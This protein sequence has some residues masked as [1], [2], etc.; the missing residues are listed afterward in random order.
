[1]KLAR[2]RLLRLGLSGGGA[3]GIRPIDYFLTTGVPLANCKRAYLPVGS[4]SLAASYINHASPGTDDANPVVAPTF[5]P[6][7]GWILNGINQYLDSGCIPASGD[8]SMVVVFTDARITGAQ[9]FLAGA[10]NVSGGVKRFSVSNYT[11]G[12]FH[13]YGLGSGGGT[14][15]LSMLPQK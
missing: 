1:M 11:G 13:Q 2:K 6:E 14:M 15:A 8:W 4:A 3:A 9:Q 7:Y 10:V 5:D 12:D